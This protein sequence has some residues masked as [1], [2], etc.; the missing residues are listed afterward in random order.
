MRG[1]GGD[2]SGSGEDD[3]GDLLEVEEE[4]DVLPG[5]EQIGEIGA[6]AVADFEGEEASGL[7]G[8]VGLGDEAAVDVQA[9][10]AGEESG[11]RLVVKD[12]RVEVCGVGFGDVGGVADDGVEGFGGVGCGFGVREGGK[13]VRPEEVDAVGQMVLTGVGLGDVEGFGGDVEGGDA[14]LREVGGEGEGEGSGAGAYVGDAQGLGG[15]GLEVGEDGFDEVLGFGTG[16]KDGG[17][18]AEIEAVE[19]LVAG[20]VLDGLAAEAA[21]DGGFVGGLVGGGEFAV[22]MGE[23][24]GSGDVEDVEEEELGVATG[25]GEEVGVAGELGGGS[26]EGL[27]ESHVCG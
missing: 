26:G 17:R 27:A 9:G 15:E 4:L 25:L 20:D 12:L 6:L 5:G 1:P 7:E 23:E 21:G 10:G 3:A 14:G 16:D 2:G 8:C 13:E 19:L 11:V 18:D 22:R 24:G